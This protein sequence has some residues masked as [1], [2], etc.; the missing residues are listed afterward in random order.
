MALI[1]QIIL[2]TGVV[3][4][5][6]S[7]AVKRNHKW[8]AIVSVLVL[9][10]TLF[11]LIFSGGVHEVTGIFIRDR[12]SNIFS[13]IILLVTVYIILISYPYI[14][15]RAEDVEEYYILIILAALGSTV[16]V[17]SRHFISFFLGLE[18]LSTSLYVLIAFIRNREKS[19]E[20]G[21]K[22]LVLAAVSSA[23]LLFGMAL[24]YADSGS[25]YFPDLGHF[26]LTR[27]MEMLS[28]A[29]LAFMMAGTG[30]KLALVPFHL[31]TPDVY[32]GAPA[33]VTAFIATVSKA[34]VFAF[35]LRFALETEVLKIQSFVVFISILSALS[36]LVGNL[37][38]LREQ[39]V[40]K[41]LAYSSISHFGYLL[42]AFLSVGEL[43]VNASIFYLVIYMIAITG[44]FAIVSFLS[45]ISSDAS[46]IIQYKDLFRSRPLVAAAFSVMLFSLAG[47]PLTAG[48]IAKFYL[49]VAGI[50]Q[51]LIVL[52]V[53]LVISSIIG[54]FFY[55]RIIVTMFSQ[56]EEQDAKSTKLGWL[57]GFVF[58]SITLALIIFGIFPGLI[59]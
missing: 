8:T 43:G 10:A 56:D 27:K 46:L 38:A 47:I 21:I 34:G 33:P 7:L 39:N 11:S 24:I 57:Y 26:F 29:G 49:L 30:F 23:L 22:Y 28:F 51:H 32:E 18:L 40:K 59:L 44:S 14:R 19:V 50:S 31:W 13:I 48:F 53:I 12:F 3:L 15:N 42:V 20:A 17:S 35:L 41:I 55:L 1:P 37:M 54:L 4:L 2:A 45:E 9:G 6:L 58:V 25:M 16:L 5:L 36:M 52:S